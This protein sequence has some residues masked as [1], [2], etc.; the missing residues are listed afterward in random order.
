MMNFYVYNLTESLFIFTMTQCNLNTSISISRIFWGGR[1]VVLTCLF[2][3]AAQ[4]SQLVATFAKRQLLLFLLI[5]ILF[6]YQ[7]IGMYSVYTCIGITLSLTVTFQ[8]YIFRYVMMTTKKSLSCYCYCNVCL[9]AL[10][11]PF[12][13]SQGPSCCTK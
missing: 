3:T 6:I 8:Q 10:N 2:L 11:R 1:F 9:Y 12:E 13:D 7:Y 5:S 4:F